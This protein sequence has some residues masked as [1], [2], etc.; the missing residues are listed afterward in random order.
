M[1]IDESLLST[2]KRCGFS[3]E[4]GISTTP[5]APIRL[6]ITVTYSELKRIPEKN[7]AL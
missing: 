3:P 6:T 4:V 5:V 2:L 7:G 1:E